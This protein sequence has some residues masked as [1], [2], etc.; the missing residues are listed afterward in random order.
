MDSV[1]A[2]VERTRLS[3]GKAY[4]EPGQIVSAIHGKLKTAPG[5]STGYADRS[6]S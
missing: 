6:V 2:V 5:S 4:G 1:R 3:T